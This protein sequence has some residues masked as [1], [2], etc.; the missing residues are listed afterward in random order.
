MATW[1]TFT[2]VSQKVDGRFKPDYWCEEAG[3][4]MEKEGEGKNTRIR[5]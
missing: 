2:L 4:K 3:G 1:L 5:K